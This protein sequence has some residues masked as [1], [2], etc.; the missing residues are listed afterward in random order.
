MAIRV[1]V[2]PSWFT[3]ADYDIRDADLR[4]SEE[5]SVDSVKRYM[6]ER[7]FDN[8]VDIIRIW[9]RFCMDKFLIDQQSLRRHFKIVLPASADEF[10]DLFLVIHLIV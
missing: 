6:R 8:T 10:I 2:K 9:M 3:A 7:L 5:R 1:A 4:K